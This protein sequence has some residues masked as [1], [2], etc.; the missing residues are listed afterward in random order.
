MSIFNG[1]W[2][3]V[4]H[5]DSKG[6]SYIR[7]QDIERVSLTRQESAE[8]DVHRITVFALGHEYL[9]TT[10][11]SLGEAENASMEVLRCIEIALGRLAKPKPAN[12]GH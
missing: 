3:D 6:L 1:Q 4:S 2:I 7:L 9:Y 12:E 5:I 10:K 11:N 8:K